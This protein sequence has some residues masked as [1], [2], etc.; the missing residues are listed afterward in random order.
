MV[1][2]RNRDYL[3]LELGVSNAILFVVA[4]RDHVFFVG[5]AIGELRSSEAHGTEFVGL[6]ATAAAAFG[7]FVL[8]DSRKSQ[9]VSIRAVVRVLVDVQ[10]VSTV[11]T[12]ETVLS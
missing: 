10:A 12:L 1:L 2:V 11:K 3:A 9:S 4:T 7:E 8:L 5:A 6:G